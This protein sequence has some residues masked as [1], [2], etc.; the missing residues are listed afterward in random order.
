MM[1][2]QELS[3]ISE[4][5][6]FAIR[7]KAK[8]ELIPVDVTEV[9]ALYPEHVCADC[10]Y[11]RRELTIIGMHPVDS[12]LHAALMASRFVHSGP[13]AQSIENLPSP[14]QPLGAEK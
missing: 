11:L 13:G 3:F 9:A 10:F 1:M 7:Q 4:P 12:P 14:D 6:P 8:R 5:A 2:N